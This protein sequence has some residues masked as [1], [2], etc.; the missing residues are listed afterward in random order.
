MPFYSDDTVRRVREAADI[1]DVVSQYVHLNKRGGAY[2]GLCPF[3]N[4]KTPSFHVQRSKQ[5][6][7]CFGCGVGGD[8]I[9]FLERYENLT[10]P[11][12]LQMLAE[13]EGI[14]LEK[15]EPTPEQR[16]RRERK[17]KLLEI[18]REA[19]KYYYRQLASD[20]GREGQ[21]YFK[22]RGLSSATIARFGL[23]YAGGYSDNLYRFLKNKGYR[24]DLLR[25]SGLV[26]MSVEKGVHDRFWNRVM[27]PITDMNA[28]IIAFGGRVLGD[29]KPKYLNSPET[30]IFDKSRTWYG[31]HLAKRSR[32]KF[33][34][35][36]EGYMDV[37]ALHQAGFDNAI[38][39]MGTALTPGHAAVLKRYV[40][41]AYLSYDSD[42]AGRKAAL[43]A[44]PILKEAGISCRVIRLAP[45]KDPDELIRALGAQEYRSRIEQAEN[46]FFFQIRCME[47]GYDLGDPEGKSRFA[48]ALAQKLLAFEEE[49][50][51]SNYLE[52]A[53]SRYNMS[54]EGLRSLVRR[55]AGAG[56]PQIRGSRQQAPGRREDV[57]RQDKDG[58]SQKLLLSWLS[59]DPSLY[60]KISAYLKPQDFRAGVLAKVAE[61]MFAA[62]HEGR[63]LSCAEIVSHFDAKEDRQEASSIFFERLVGVEETD[64]KSRNEAIKEIIIRLRTHRLE[65]LQERMSSVDPAVAGEAF[66]RMIAEKKELENMKKKDFLL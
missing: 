34:I 40:S 44:I 2:I 38:A 10:F 21:L 49:I 58:D 33:F 19:G 61:E 37:I 56:L 9:S 48:E 46:F 24:D 43:R 5:L 17:E 54:T 59:E 27:F 51:R 35:L 32:E 14:R 41:E 28:K 29:G 39:S 26:A 13:R 22:K 20:K 15:Q 64:A 30:D 66:N 4:E 25:D 53:A 3:H 60:E 7:H 18:Q 52:A 12:A 50:E 47:E 42:G 1:V 45:Y 36:C 57:R 63:E 8:V 65:R 62:L 23:G 55:A 11:E 6:F 31:L 16:Q